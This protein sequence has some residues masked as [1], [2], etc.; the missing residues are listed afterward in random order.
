MFIMPILINIIYRITLIKYTGC[1]ILFLCLTNLCCLFLFQGF[2]A[3]C[4]L[5]T[6][7]FLDYWNTGTIITWIHKYISIFKILFKNK[8]CSTQQKYD[9]VL[10]SRWLLVQGRQSFQKWH[11]TSS[12]QLLQ[13]YQLRHQPVK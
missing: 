8:I 2:L 5:F 4:L 1:E 9:L 10:W 13:G 11:G 3:V 12:N 7:I 6:N